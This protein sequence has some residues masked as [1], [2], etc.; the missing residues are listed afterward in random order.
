MTENTVCVT[1]KTVQKAIERYVAERC[2][3]HFTTA[4]I[5]RFMGVEEYPV[6]AAVSWLARYGLIE[7]VPG[8]RSVR[9]RSAQTNSKAHCAYYSVAMY[10]AKERFGV[11]D[12]AALMRAFC[13]Y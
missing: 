9:Y 11:A 5:A 13:C 3:E 6:R 8:V 12:F 7:I 10:R 1:T 2:V 4:D